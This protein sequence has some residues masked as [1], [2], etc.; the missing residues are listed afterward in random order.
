[1]ARTDPQIN[2]RLPSKLK[3]RLVAAAQANTRTL[4]A[5]IVNRLEASFRRAAGRTDEEQQSELAK[6]IRE[7]RST[8]EKLRAGFEEFRDLALVPD[9]TQF[10][11]PKSET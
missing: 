11:K 9:F 1:M 8:V 2:V 6:E 3:E 10:A 4:N 7:F 5:E